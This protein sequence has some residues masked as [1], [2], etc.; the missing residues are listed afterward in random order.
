MR[1]G[2]FIDIILLNTH[3]LK[4]LKP[5]ERILDTEGKKE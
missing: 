1:N 5:S 2:H 4:I 3:L